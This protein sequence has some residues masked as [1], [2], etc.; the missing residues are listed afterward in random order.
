[1][2]TEQNVDIEKMKTMSKNIKLKLNEEERKKVL[3][4]IQQNM[5]VHVRYKHYRW[6]KKLIYQDI[7]E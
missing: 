1:M 4:V 2:F 5:N 6:C 3:N 7:L